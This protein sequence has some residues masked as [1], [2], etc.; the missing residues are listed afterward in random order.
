MSD[1]DAD[2]QQLGA[3]TF[4][5]K[6]VCYCTGEVLELY[7]TNANIVKSSLSNIRKCLHYGGGVCYHLPPGATN[8]A[9]TLPKDY[10][11]C[12]SAGLQKEYGL[13]DLHGMTRY[14]SI[15]HSEKARKEYGEIKKALKIL[16]DL[17]QPLRVLLDRN[18]MRALLKRPKGSKYA[19]LNKTAHPKQD[20]TRRPAF[21]TMILWL[22]QLPS[23]DPAFNPDAKFRRISRDDQGLFAVYACPLRVDLMTWHTLEYVEVSIFFAV[24][25]IA[26]C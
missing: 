19:E 14:K 23:P 16:V 25:A 12:I 17:D 2:L 4:L 22:A 8:A 6:F 20:L 11:G 18:V 24:F 7:R 5:F 26:L 13:Q 3:E 1:G 9:V 21:A 10:T 15:E